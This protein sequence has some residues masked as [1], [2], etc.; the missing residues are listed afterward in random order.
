MLCFLRSPR[1]QEQVDPD[2]GRHH[3]QRAHTRS[4]DQAR[5]QGSP[6]TGRAAGG[7]RREEG[8]A[9]GADSGQEQGRC[10]CGCSARE[11]CGSRPA[12]A[13]QGEEGGGF[14]SERSLGPVGHERR[15]RGR[16]PSLWR[17]RS[18]RRL[19]RRRSA[20]LDVDLLGA[21][22]LD[23]GDD[24]C[25]VDQQQR[26]G[27]T[28]TSASRLC[29]AAAAGAVCWARAR[30]W[31]RSDEGARRWPRRCQR[32]RLQP[33]VPAAARRGARC[34]VRA[35]P[36]RARRQRQPHRRPVWLPR[37]GAAAPAADAGPTGP[38]AAV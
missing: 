21:K 13:G 9:A 8:G 23:P 14:R 37:R 32:R 2:Q 24:G 25:A 11:G 15:C 36:C 4:V 22:W 19:F 10:R 30:S 35:R 1:R 3:R 6:R 34:G 33:S 28:A 17:R 38:G 12:A 16:H 7:R 18:R 5:G 29:S 26:L 27:A 20:C 31:R